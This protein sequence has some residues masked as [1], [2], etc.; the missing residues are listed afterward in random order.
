MVSSRSESNVHGKSQ[1]TM[2]G[3]QQKWVVDVVLSNSGVTY[4]NNLLVVVLICNLCCDRLFP[5]IDIVMAVRV[6]RSNPTIR[7]G[8]LRGLARSAEVTSE[9]EQASS[10][11][12]FAVSLL[13]HPSVGSRISRR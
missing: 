4:G 8:I 2:Q 9:Q 12:L 5:C 7:V 10:V 11:C 3:G 6:Q 1:E 13:H